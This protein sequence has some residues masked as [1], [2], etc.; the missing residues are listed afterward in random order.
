MTGKPRVSVLL[1]AYNAEPYV[2]AAIESVLGQ[3]YRDWEIIATDDRSVDGTAAVLEDYARRD[4]RIRA[5]RNASNAGMTGNW[6]L[7]LERASG[8]LVLKLDA[9]D[10]LRPQTLEI[11]AAALEAEDVTGAGVRTLVCDAM[12]EPRDV[13]PADDAM[14]RAGLDPQLDHLLENRNWYVIAAHGHQ[15]WHS[16][17][18]MF[19]RDFLQRTGGWDE[20]FGCASDTEIIW[21]LLEGPGRFAH[22]GYEGV[23]YRILEGSVS[24]TFRKNDWLRW[25]GTA[26]NLMT[27]GRVRKRRTL[28]WGLRSW[29]ADLYDSWCR[30][31]D[32]NRRALPPAFFDKIRSAVAESPPPPHLD[33]LLWRLRTWIPIR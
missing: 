2:R 25:E 5:F 20:R 23:L 19:R 9:D 29:H 1:P 15:L 24:D 21:R 10:A 13:L 22:S 27:L 32:E 3:T 6:N 18:V 28:P 30:S 33:R 16:C 26:A 4:P 31:L 7:C 17:A 8:D 14:R 11:L 12:L